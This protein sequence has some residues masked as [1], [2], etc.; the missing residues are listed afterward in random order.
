M[1]GS[2]LSIQLI[3]DLRQGLS[4]DVVLFGHLLRRLFDLS[5][6]GYDDLLLFLLKL[7]LLGLC[8]IM[9]LVQLSL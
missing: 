4:L 7:P 2:Q 6:H 5:L 9:G 3:V 8:P 1:H